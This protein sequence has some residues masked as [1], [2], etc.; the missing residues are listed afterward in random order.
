MSSAEAPRH[1]TSTITYG[2]GD[3]GSSWVGTFLSVQ[4][5]ARMM[6][7]MARL[8]ATRCFAK[9]SIKMAVCRE[10]W[11]S[12]IRNR[13]NETAVGKVLKY[14]IVGGCGALSKS[15]DGEFHQTVATS[16]GVTARQLTSVSLS[17]PSSM[18]RSRPSLLAIRV[19]EPLSGRK[20]TRRSSAVAAPTATLIAT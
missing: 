13:A 12:G 19:I 4:N 14:M 2:C 10:D 8:A 17:R 18:M 15:A 9:S 11:Q 6:I 16:S 5:P 20:Q 7:N 3:G 1:S